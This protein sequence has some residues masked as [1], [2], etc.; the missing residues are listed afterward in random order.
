MHSST[1][2]CKSSLS[3]GGRGLFSRGGAKHVLSWVVLYHQGAQHPS[4]SGLGPAFHFSISG[5]K[6]MFT[7]LHSA[8]NVPS[9]LS[10]RSSESTTGMGG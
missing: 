1:S 5:L 10:R 4:I 2:A 9:G 7:A 6:S 3:G 8:R